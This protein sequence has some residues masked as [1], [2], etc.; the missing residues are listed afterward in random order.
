[1]ARYGLGYEELA[2]ENPGLIYCSISGIGEL[3]VESYR[4]MTFLLGPRAAS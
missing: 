3:Q 2:T 4:D 1:M